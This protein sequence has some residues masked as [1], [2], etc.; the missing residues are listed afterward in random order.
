MSLEALMRH[1]IQ[2]WTPATGAEDAWGHVDPAPWVEGASVRGLVQERAGKEVAGPDLGGTVIVNAVVYLP[3]G[4]AVTPRDRLERTDT[5]A[6]YDVLYVRDAAGQGH[7]L[8]IDCRRI[9]P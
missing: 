8:E 2:V 1:S 9:E 7:H 5:G 6:M 3:I 4:T